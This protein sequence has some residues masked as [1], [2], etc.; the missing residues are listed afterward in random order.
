MPIFRF[1]VIFDVYRVWRFGDGNDVALGFRLV[2]QELLDRTSRLPDAVLVFDQSD[3]NEAFAVFA[4]TDAGRDRDVGL[5][6]QQFRE[7][8]GPQIAYRAREPAPRR[9]WWRG[10]PEWES[11]RA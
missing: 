10:A 1:S 9:T 11:P 5:L 3:A 4:E 6:D 2:G 8:D 7:F